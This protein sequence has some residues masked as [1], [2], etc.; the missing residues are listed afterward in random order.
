MAS[1]SFCVTLRANS[2]H[3]VANHIQGATWQH[4]RGSVQ[5]ARDVGWI[6]KQTVECYER[7][8]GRE[9]REQRIECNSCRNQQDAIFA[10][11]VVNA[12]QYVFP[13]ACR[14]LRRGRFTPSSTLLLYPVVPERLPVVAAARDIGDP[15]LG[16]RPVRVGLLGQAVAIAS[17]A[18]AQRKAQYSVVLIPPA[19]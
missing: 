2:V 10:D 8:N 17:A 18:A 5:V 1:P 11:V 9:N 13:P 19:G 14:N 6:S 4:S 7:G 15:A 3:L 12:Q 16:D